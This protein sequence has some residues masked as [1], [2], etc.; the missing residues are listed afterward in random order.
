MNSYRC[1]VCGTGQTFFDNNIYIRY[2]EKTGE[3]IV[4]GIT[5]DEQIYD[6]L[7]GWHFVKKKDVNVMDYDVVIVMTTDSTFKNIRSEMIRLGFSDDVIIPYKVI[8]LYGFSIEKYIAL[9]RNTPTI[10]ASNC[11]G[12]IVYNQL[13]LEFKSPFINMFEEHEDYIKILKNLSYYMD[14]DLEFI[15]EGLDN[16]SGQ[17]YPIVK[18]DD[19]YL[20]FNHYRTYEDALECWNRRKKR[21]NWD[22]LFVMFFEDN[23]RRAKEF[24]DLCY[25][26]KICFTSFKIKEKSTEFIECFDKGTLKGKALWQVVNEIAQGKYVYYDF[27]ELLLN[28]KIVKQSKF[29]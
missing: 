28:G 22:N 2:L 21:I 10:I 15:R 12:G 16:I 7:Y 24:A 23:E 26:K 3:I 9:K 11:W 13:G 27:F 1:L 4:N 5:S 25:N 29:S 18:C 20:H 19:V 17:V 14:C 6:E 8:P